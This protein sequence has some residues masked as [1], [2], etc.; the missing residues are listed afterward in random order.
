MQRL[1]KCE[2]VKGMER[3]SVAGVEEVGSR[4]NFTEAEVCSQ[5]KGGI[6]FVLM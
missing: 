2:C 3:K 4:I 1:S 6:P 5:G